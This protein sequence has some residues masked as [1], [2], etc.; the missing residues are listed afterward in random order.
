MYP[1]F[2][3][4]KG[5]NKDWLNTGLGLQGGKL[6]PTEKEGQPSL[7]FDLPGLRLGDWVAPLLQAFRCF[8]RLGKTYMVL[9]QNGSAGKRMQGAELQWRNDSSISCAIQHSSLVIFMETTTVKQNLA[10]C[11]QRFHRNHC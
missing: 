6:T 1:E 8:T 4:V 7:Q 9:V 11:D 2:C 10:R 5:T 3:V